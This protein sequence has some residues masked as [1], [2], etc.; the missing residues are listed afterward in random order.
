[1]RN[2]GKSVVISPEGTRSITPKLSPFKKGPF[3]LAI[4]AGVPVVPIVI[5]N[6]GDVA[7]KGD[8]IFRPATVEVD[9]LEPVDTSNWSSETIEEHVAE[10]RGLFLEALG[11]SEAK[12]AAPS[13]PR[14]PAAGASQQSPREK[15][16]VKSAARKKVL[17]KK[18]RILKAP[19]P[20]REAAPGVPKAAGKPPLKKK[21]GKKKALKKKLPAKNAPVKKELK[22][23]LGKKTLRKK[24]LKK[25]PVAGSAG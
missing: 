16:A 7:P 14:Q 22:K 19:G 25:K 3:H 9:V 24:A 10:V 12:P 23:T 21:A 17:K 18:A 2:Q 11:Q 6:A 8:F 13:A 4:Q 5:H 15:P 1:M 20:D